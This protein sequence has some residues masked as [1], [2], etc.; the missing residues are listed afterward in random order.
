MRRIQKLSIFLVVLTLIAV[1]VI[2]AN[3]WWVGYYAGV[4]VTEAEPLDPSECE[5]VGDPRCY[6]IPDGTVV[7]FKII[8][9]NLWRLYNFDISINS[10][11]Y[12][13]LKVFRVLDTDLVYSTTP[14]DPG[15]KLFFRYNYDLDIPAGLTEISRRTWVSFEESRYGT[16][17]NS[18]WVIEYTGVTASWANQYFN[19]DFLY[20]LQNSGNNYRTPP[21]IQV[22][23]SF[24]LQSSQYNTF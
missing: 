17:E 8:V 18:A 1:P 13:H 10:I 6:P 19:L 20:L 21:T 22:F 3:A 24:G 14:Q 23:T 7:A 2:M 15:D 4:E 9:N 5:I 12:S 16:G 11:G